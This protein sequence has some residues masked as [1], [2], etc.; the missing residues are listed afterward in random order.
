MHMQTL[1]NLVMKAACNLIK[2]D[3]VLTS[4]KVIKLLPGLPGAK[5][6]AFRCCG[7]EKGGPCRVQHDHLLQL[8]VVIR[9]GVREAQ[10]VGD[11]QSRQEHLCL[12]CSHLSGVCSERRELCWRN[13]QLT[14]LGRQMW[15]CCDVWLPL[16]LVDLLTLTVC[17]LVCLPLLLCDGPKRQNK[18]TVSDKIAEILNIPSVHSLLQTCTFKNKSGCCFVSVVVVV[19]VLNWVVTFI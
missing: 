5:N 10:G 2:R 9:G 15:R 17:L 13:Q 1:A 14:P 4:S 7:V 16:F 8:G 19:V 3:L 6:S 18:S 12:G 11:L